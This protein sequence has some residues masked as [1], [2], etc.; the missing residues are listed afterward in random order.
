MKGTNT[1]RQF[2]G[3]NSQQEFKH[4]SGDRK[5]NAD[6]GERKTIGNIAN[7]DSVSRHE[8]CPRP[9]DTYCPMQREN[10]CFMS[11][12]I[13][14]YSDPENCGDYREYKRRGK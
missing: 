8:D 7:S 9:A 10:Y 13:C 6:N 4:L 1:R 14:G 11:G 3:F 12:E 2:A 5:P